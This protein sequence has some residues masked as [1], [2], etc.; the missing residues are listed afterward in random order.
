M[1]SVGEMI[2]I[3]A[4]PFVNFTGEVKAV[5]TDTATLKVKVNIYGRTEPVELHFSDVEKIASA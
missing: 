4:G 1:F 2:R 5:N 3:I